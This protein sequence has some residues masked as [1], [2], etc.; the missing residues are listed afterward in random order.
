MSENASVRFGRWWTFCTHD[1]NWVVTLN[2]AYSNFVK[3]ADNRIQIC[4]LA[5]A[6][7]VEKF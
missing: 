7:L 4:S 5:Y 6:N 2:M 3:V 1:I